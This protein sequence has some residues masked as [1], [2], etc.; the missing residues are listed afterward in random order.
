MRILFGVALLLSQAEAA[1]KAQVEVFKEPTWVT[2][3]PKHMNRKLTEIVEQVEKCAE[4]RSEHQKWETLFHEASDA[5]ETALV[6]WYNTHPGA[7]DAQ[8]ERDDIANR[9]VYTRYREL[10]GKF[11]SNK[12]LL[13]NCL[14][15]EIDGKS[16]FSF[17]IH[18]HPT[19]KSKKL[20]QIEVTLEMK[21]VSYA[22]LGFLFSPVKGPKSKFVLDM[23]TPCE[24][25]GLYHTVLARKDEWLQFPAKPFQKP[26]WVKFSSEWGPAELARLKNLEVVS[27]DIH[28]LKGD[29]VVK[30]VADGKAFFSKFRPETESQPE[31]APTEPEEEQSLTIKSLY[32]SHR[33]LKIAKTY[34]DGC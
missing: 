11:E 9:D 1:P 29:F 8:I 13:L 3:T 6:Q 30:R 32:D 5:R 34:I 10:E 15:T 17:P 33:H 26:V 31:Q 27:L 18:A 20:G 4:L 24:Y 19:E 7:K 22:K 21:Q 28:P 23:N 14:K 25:D 16:F 12:K 2:M